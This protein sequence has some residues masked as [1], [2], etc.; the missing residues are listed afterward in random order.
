MIWLTAA[1]GI[2]G[3][4]LRANQVV[5]KPDY[6]A[7]FLPLAENYRPGDCVTGRPR[8]WNNRVHLAWE[9]YY[10]NRGVLRL[11]PFDSLPTASTGCERLWVVRDR[12]WWMNPDQEA[13]KKSQ[14]IIAMLSERYPVVERYYHP[15]IELQLLERQ[16]DGAGQ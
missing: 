8:M 12:T 7:G 9:V 14:Q 4:A 11:V 10:R 6:R 2:C 3:L 16:P 1:V 13:A 15:A 5:T